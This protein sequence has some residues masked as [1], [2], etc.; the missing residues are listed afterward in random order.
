MDGN[1][2]IAEH[3]V[4]SSVDC[5]AELV[6]NFAENGDSSA[7]ICKKGNRFYIDNFRELE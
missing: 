5:L 7:E 1:K 2:D 4:C 6:S 3:L